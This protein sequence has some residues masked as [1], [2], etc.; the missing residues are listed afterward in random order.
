[1]KDLISRLKDA[2]AK[3]ARYVQTRNEIARMP[4]NIALDLDIY[5]G[6]AHRIA[7]KAVYGG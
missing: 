4:Q 6:D 3:R 5:P 1:M 7:H 2:A